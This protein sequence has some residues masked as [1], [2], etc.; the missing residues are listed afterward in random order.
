M[1]R[2]YCFCAPRSFRN[3]KLVSPWVCREI[4]W[5]TLSSLETIVSYNSPGALVPW[6]LR[7][8]LSPTWPDL[9]YPTKSLLSLA[10]NL[11]RPI[12]CYIIHHS[13]IVC[14]SSL[15]SFHFPFPSNSI[16]TFQKLQIRHTCYYHLLE[17][18]YLRGIGRYFELVIG[19]STVS[20]I[21][22]SAGY[23]QEL[24][25]LYRRF[26]VLEV[27]TQVARSRLDIHVGPKPNGELWNSTETFIGL[28][29]YLMEYTFQ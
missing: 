24:D 23:R 8:K 16:S 9:V 29:R 26:S 2:G 19:L 4:S 18:Q 3:R 15:F 17:M 11:D 5:S 14:H 13:N 20:L 7:H 27:Q 22:T 28:E 25:A 1:G 21:W 10:Y 6:C 12:S